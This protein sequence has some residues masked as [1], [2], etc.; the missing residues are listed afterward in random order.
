MGAISI[1]PGG[2]FELSGAPLET[3]QETCRESNQHPAVLR[4]VAEQMGKRFLGI[5]G[6]RKWSLDETPRMPKSTYG[7]MRRNMLKVRRPGRRK[8]ER[9]GKRRS[10]R[11]I[12]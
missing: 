10:S 4:E 2:Q 6:S 8:S 7:I 9:E 5:G 11:I 1:E 12:L 3:I